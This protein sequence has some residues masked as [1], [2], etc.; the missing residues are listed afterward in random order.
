MLASTYYTVSNEIL[1]RAILEIP[2]FETSIDLNYRTGNFFYDQWL[3][4]DRF[5][6]TVWEEILNSLPVDIGQARLIKLKPEECYR[7]HADMDDRYHLSIK[8]EKSFLIDL[9]NHIMYPTVPDGKWYLMDAGK[10]HSAVNF[11]GQPRIQLVVRKL[12]TRGDIKN[13][14]TVLIQKSKDIPNFRYVFDDV[15]S[16]WLNKM[17][18]E[19]KLDNF[20]M[21]SDDGVSF[22]I[23]KDHIADLIATCPAE[24]KIII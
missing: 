20:Q 3:V 24:F 15:F 18:K 6:N 21:L 23:D 11:G 14:Q 8:G 22:T 12:L 1:Q 2:E 10:R 19:G 7:S 9:D 16:P 4:S 5:E 13:S 17:D